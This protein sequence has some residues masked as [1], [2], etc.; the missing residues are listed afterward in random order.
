MCVHPNWSS[1]SLART[2]AHPPT[3]VTNFLEL[4]STMELNHGKKVVFCPENQDAKSR[5][6]A[7]E[8]LFS[9]YEIVELLVLANLN[10][11][12][13]LNWMCNSSVDRFLSELADDHSEDSLNEAIGKYLKISGKTS[14]LNLLISACAPVCAPFE[15]MS[16]DGF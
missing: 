11:E 1:E 15:P 3:P 2:C 14:A 7:K 8:I 10:R 4:F 5:K 16:S 12:T 6:G 9:L 13:S